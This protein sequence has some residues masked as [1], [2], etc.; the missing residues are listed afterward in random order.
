MGDKVEDVALTLGDLLTEMQDDPSISDYIS[1][2]E[3]DRLWDS[4]DILMDA[5]KMMDQDEE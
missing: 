5:S 4:Y 1:K 3:M 2:D